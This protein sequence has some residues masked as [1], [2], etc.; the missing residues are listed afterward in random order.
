[1]SYIIHCKN[2][3]CQKV[4]L[5]DS[6]YHAKR[7]YLEQPMIPGELHCVDADDNT[8]IIEMPNVWCKHCKKLHTYT[9]ADIVDTTNMSPNERMA[10]GKEIKN[11]LKKLQEKQ[12]SEIL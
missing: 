1:M 5:K 8:T 9:Q 4:I 12:T 11:K 3:D 2:K 6:P 7:K 10:L